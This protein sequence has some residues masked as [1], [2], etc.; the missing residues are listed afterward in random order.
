MSVHVF[1]LCA[2]ME[3]RGQVVGVWSSTLWSLG[4]ELRLLL[5]VNVA[6]LYHL[7]VTYLDQAGLDWVN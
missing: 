1:I 4:T 7:G 3:V 2:Q 6:V 5:T